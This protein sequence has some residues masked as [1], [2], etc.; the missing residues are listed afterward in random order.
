MQQTG[1]SMNIC[2]HDKI[3]PLKSVSECMIC[4]KNINSKNFNHHNQKSTV[5][6]GFEGTEKAV[7]SRTSNYFRYY[8][9]CRLVFDWLLNITNA[10]EL[11]HNF[12]VI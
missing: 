3:M 4:H 11:L 8:K 2:T 10:F 7:L 9:F 5:F 12:C 6:Q 1:Y